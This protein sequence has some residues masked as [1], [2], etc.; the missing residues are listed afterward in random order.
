LIEDVAQSSAEINWSYASIE[1]LD[2]HDFSTRL[3]PFNLGNAIDNPASPDNQTLKVGDIVTVFSRKDLP[4]PRKQHQAFVQ[5]G[6]EVNAA[7]VYRIQDGDTL[8]SLVERAGGFTPQ[9]FLYGAQLSRLSIRQIEDQDLQFS[10][11][12]LERELTNREVRQ[13]EDTLRLERQE[14]LI[15]RLS[16]IHS[17][18]RV[19]LGIKPT[20]ETIEDIPEIPLEDGD[21]FTVPANPTTIQVLGEVYNPAAFQYTPKRRLGK[22]LDDAG[23]ATR[24]ADFKRA[25]LVHA[26]GTV[27]SKQ[28]RGQHWGRNFSSLVVLPGDALVLPPNLKVKGRGFIDELPVIAQ[29][30]SGSSMTALLAYTAT[31]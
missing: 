13:G 15:A 31:R 12:R 6:G 4:L 22:Y 23:G 26:N 25:F 1:R 18:G 17:V 29:I 30:L 5:I 8:R 21:N 2:D 10:L 3:I 11:K 7:G 28:T 20:A 16:E 24:E 19:I 27:V 14:K 9:A